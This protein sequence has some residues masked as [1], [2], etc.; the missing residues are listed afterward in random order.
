MKMD[1]S[2][3]LEGRCALVTGA[4]RG[5][6]QA[7]AVR[8]AELGAKVAC[9]ATTEAGLTTTLTRIAE[10]CGDDTRARGFA[11]DVSKSA[12]VETLLREAKEHGFEPDVLVNNAGITRDNLLMRLS[13]EDFDRVFEVNLKGAFL[14]S[15]ALARPLMKKRSGSIINIGSVVGI[16][17]NAGQANY[18]ASKAGLIGFTKS[19]AKELAGRG[20]TANVVAP[21]FIETDMTSEIPEVNRKSLEAG[22]P[23]GRFGSPQDV[24]ELVAFLASPGASYITG[25]VLSVDG[26]MAI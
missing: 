12:D 24:A 9:V 3:S 21:G 5:I 1:A 6:G 13:E 17:G 15:K 10:S 16:V 23:L 26:G 7:I 11:A 2:R 22:I 4:S 8:L 14:L 25:Q 18:A 20:I 19:L